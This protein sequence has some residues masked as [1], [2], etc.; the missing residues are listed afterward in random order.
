MHEGIEHRDLTRIWLFSGCTQAE[1]R[2]IGKAMTEVTVPAGTLLVEQGQP[3]LLFFVVLAGTA[4]VRRGRRSV[5]TLGP[6]DFFGELSLL[7]HRPRS[8]SVVCTTEMTL[9]VLRQRQFQKVLRETPTL[10]VRL[11]RVM[12]QRLRTS[13][14]LVHD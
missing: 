8:A 12:A 11:L 6:G 5:A 2:K 4:S 3:G 13:E 10:T 9:L 1:L 7:D 14:A